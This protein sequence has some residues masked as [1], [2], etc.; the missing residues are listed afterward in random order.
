MHKNFSKRHNLYGLAAKPVN[1]PF[2][3]FKIPAK[4]VLKTSP[5]KRRSMSIESG[6]ASSRNVRKQRVFT[7]QVSHLLDKVFVPGRGDQRLYR[8]DFLLTAGQ[9]AIIFNYSTY[10]KI[11]KKSF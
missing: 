4:T 9:N 1:R 3:F 10:R 8:K 6:D 7:N 5:E 11:V 2:S